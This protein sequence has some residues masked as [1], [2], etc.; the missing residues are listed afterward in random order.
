[1]ALVTV[2]LSCAGLDLLLY[3]SGA[4]THYCCD[5]G[6]CDAGAALD[7][8]SAVTLEL[9]WSGVSAV[10]LVTVTLELRRTGYCDTGAAPDGLE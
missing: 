2:T 9:R 10:T 8:S 3:T 6:Y 4:P 1:M 5:T 7:W